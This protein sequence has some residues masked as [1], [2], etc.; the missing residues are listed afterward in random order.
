MKYFKIDV[1]DDGNDIHK[2]LSNVWLMTDIK[3]N[4]SKLTLKNVNNPDII[5]NTIS[6]WKTTEIDCENTQEG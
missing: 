3:Y 2:N 4:G 5:I 1:F 6:A